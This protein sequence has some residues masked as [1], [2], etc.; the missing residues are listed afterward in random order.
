MPKL[1]QL[2]PAGEH[3]RR[4]EANVHPPNWVNPEP[5]RQYDLVVIGAGTAGLVAAAGAAGLGAKVA[6]VERKFMG[7]DCLIA[8]CV[9]SKGIIASAR[10]AA[11]VRDAGDFGVRVPDGVG[12][13]FANVMER[14]RRLRADISPHDSAARFR[15]LGVD[16]FLGEAQFGGKNTVEIGDQKLRFKKAV[17]ATGGRA[18]APLISGLDDVE[19][20]T[21][22]TVFSLTELPRRF[23][24]I[25]AGPIGCE[26]A[27]TFA[28]FGS[29][30]FLIEAAHGI[31]PREDR[32]AAAIVKKSLLHDGVELLCCGEETRIRAA[33]NGVRIQLNSHGQQY[34][35]TV[36]K[37]LVAAGR[38]PNVEGLNLEAVGVEYDPHNG[39]AVN[40]RLQTTN[41]RI[42]AAGDVCSN[43]KFTHAADFQARIVIRN[44]LFFG[45]SKASNLTIPWCTYTSP[46]I[47]HVGL[48]GREAKDQ[49]T[50][51]DTFVQQ[52]ADVD[53]AVLEGD[54]EGF[55]KVH[56]RRG[57]DRI[58]GATIVAQNAGDLIAEIS[59]AATHGLG[60]KKIGRTV[61]PYPT[62]AEA[63]RKLGDAYNRTRVTPRIK[64]IF[65]K[66][67]EW[68]R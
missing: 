13:D 50:E 36:D 52:M 45:Y 39:V 57:T 24:V 44:A 41:K 22:E 28:R 26:L 58:V 40:D 56:V 1:P 49:G 64:W 19:Y 5:L 11:A 32:D 16:V 7:G 62:Q 30:V 48:T 10:I 63:I 31:L 3:N 2:Q 43:Y 54:T 37:L 46:E 21:N 6:L 60:L 4:L 59:L 67:L 27:Q 14:M 38:A 53:R 68:T 51:I 9:P 20:M 25:G 61:H 17:I 66:W 55:V 18:A 8:G 12:V 29:E 15:K 34:D 42:Y 23:G 65:K 47:A 33:A 35:V